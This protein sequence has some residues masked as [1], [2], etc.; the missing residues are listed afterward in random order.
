VLLDTLRAD[1]LSVYGHSRETSPNIDRL[2]MRGVLFE[3]AVTSAPW[4]LPATVSLLTGEYP[5]ARVFDRRLQRSLVERIR[6]AGFATG[7]FVE[8]G[9]VSE[10]FGFGRGFEHFSEFLTYTRRDPAASLGSKKAAAVHDIGETFGAAIDWLEAH[11][12]LPFFLLVHTYEVHIPYTRLDYAEELERGSLP[13]LFGFREA[14]EAVQQRRS[15]TERRY[16]GALY[17]GGVRTADH[18]V[19]RL[20]EALRRVGRSHDTLVVVTSDHGEDLGHRPD[21]R[22]GF[23]GHTLYD[24]LV[25]VPL[26]VFDP[27][28][29][30]SV[31][32]VFTQVRTLDVLPTVLERLGITAAEE[33]H[34]RSL[35]PLME[36]LEVEHRPA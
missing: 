11:S 34:G 27:T 2:A 19:G 5:T 13:R 18:H 21:G 33:I 22:A 23:H 8:G 35:V 14:Q 26:I 17:D 9:F 25:R 7:A 16:I 31:K 30:F 20:L 29:D 15:P 32:R 24:E 28:R 1:R 6:D 12:D 36:G 3:Q 4:T 10:Q